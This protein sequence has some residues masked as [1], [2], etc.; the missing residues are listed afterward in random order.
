MAK[1]F[2]HINRWLPPLLKSKG[3]TMEKFSRK[4]KVSRAA[5]YAYMTDRN[6]PDSQ[7]MLRMCRVLGVPFEEGL[8]QY[9]PKQVGRPR[10]K[11][12]R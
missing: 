11:A 10:E 3:L 8:K 12:K 2:N 9:V 7:I 4:V 1:D 5:V 6:R